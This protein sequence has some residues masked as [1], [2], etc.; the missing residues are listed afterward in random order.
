[1]LLRDLNTKENYSYKYIKVLLSMVFY[2]SGHATFVI[3]M[4]PFLLVI[5]YP[6]MLDCLSM[7]TFVKGLYNF[8][9]GSNGTRAVPFF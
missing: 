2:I 6:V 1:M 4:Q 9:S 3:L 8:I 7:D 5:T